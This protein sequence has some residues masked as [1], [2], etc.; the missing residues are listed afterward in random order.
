MKTAKQSDLA[1]FLK[2][3]HD[4]NEIEKAR[5]SGSLKVYQQEKLA[6]LTFSD[7]HL[8]DVRTNLAR[9]RLGQILIDQGLLSEDTLQSVMATSSGLRIGEALVASRKINEINRDQGLHRQKLLGLMQ[10]FL[11]DTPVFEKKAGQATDDV[12]IDW[13]PLAHEISRLVQAD[14][15]LGQVLSGFH[16]TSHLDRPIDLGEKPLWTILAH[17]REQEV[18][19]ILRIRRQQKVYELVL[20]NGIPLTLYEGSVARPRQFVWIRQTSDEVEH[21]FQKTLLT[22]MGF[23]SGTLSFRTL[24][25]AT[26]AQELTKGSPQT[27]LVVSEEQ[28]RFSL[29]E[30]LFAWRTK[31]ANHFHGVSI[32]LLKR[33]KFAQKS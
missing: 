7:G 1:S 18:S 20:K 21:F 31:L 17:Y 24:Q 32:K 28:R 8:V 6:K 3:E 15:F 29:S 26:V 22:W 5:F 2:L 25:A 33:L 27:K 10:V 19:G 30:F 23:S 14:R 16:D 9:F 13:R 12:S 11:W 4:L